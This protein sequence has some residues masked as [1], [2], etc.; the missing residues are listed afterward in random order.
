MSIAD[1]LAAIKA[2]VPL[3]YQAGYDKGKSE[4]GDV[5]VNTLYISDAAP[6]SS[7]GVDGDVWIVR[8]S[9]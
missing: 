2:N 5:S 1:Q 8:S 7:V 9:T 6:T 4:G 3:V